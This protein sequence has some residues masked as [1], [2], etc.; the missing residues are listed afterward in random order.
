M[1]RHSDVGLFLR[2][3]SLREIKPSLSIFVFKSGQQPTQL[4]WLTCPGRLECLRIDL[5]FY[6]EGQMFEAVRLGGKEG[7]REGKRGMGGVRTHVLVLQRS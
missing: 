4:T 7:G 1:I 5:L 3:R 6:T 2:V